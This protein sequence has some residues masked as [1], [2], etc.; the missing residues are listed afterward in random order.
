LTA[1]AAKRRRRNDAVV[2]A[3]ETGAFSYREIAGHFGLHLA[4]IGRIVQ[5]R[6]QQ[7][8]N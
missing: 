6:M 5:A 7:G 1:I 4:T 2:A 3:R 8:E